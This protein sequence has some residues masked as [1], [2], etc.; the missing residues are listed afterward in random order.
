MKKSPK[1]LE[2][3]G[4]DEI[5]VGKKK[6]GGRATGNRARKISEFAISFPIR[7]SKPNASSDKE[8]RGPLAAGTDV[9]LNLTQ[10]FYR[11]KNNAS[12]SKIGT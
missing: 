10:K 1:R 4:R 6:L 9:G 8:N 7:D 5:F 11:N 12:I 2:N 3:G